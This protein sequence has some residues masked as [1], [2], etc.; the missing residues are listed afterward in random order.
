[1]IHPEEVDPFMGKN[2]DLLGGEGNVLHS[3]RDHHGARFEWRGNV[4]TNRLTLRILA[5]YGA[6][7]AVFRA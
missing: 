6:P 2:F 7:A 4:R 3:A 1:M 5:T